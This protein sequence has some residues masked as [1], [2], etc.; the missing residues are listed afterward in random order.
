MTGKELYGPVG[1]KEP[2]LFN[3]QLGWIRVFCKECNIDYDIREVDNE[4]THPA[5]LHVA[6][7]DCPKGH[8]CEAR[9]L[10][11]SFDD[12]FLKACGVEA[13]KEEQFGQARPA[14]EGSGDNCGR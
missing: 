9:R 13:P 8:H 12:D 2:I 10:W 1:A 7:F 5:A 11:N 3:G 4:T 14:S 6:R